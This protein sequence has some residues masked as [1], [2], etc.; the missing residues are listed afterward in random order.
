MSEKETPTVGAESAVA[1]GRQPQTP[2]QLLASMAGAPTPNQ[3]ESWKAQAPGNHVRL[4]TPDMKRIYILR[5]LSGLEL[6]T[7]NKSIPQNAEDPDREQQILGSERALLWTNTSAATRLTAAELRAGTAGLP[8]TLFSVVMELS[9][10]F[11][12]EHI[13]MLSGDL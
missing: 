2:Q 7:L 1:E 9:D 10:F 8:T 12:P 3:V 6:A 11:A 13:A 4:F 5:G